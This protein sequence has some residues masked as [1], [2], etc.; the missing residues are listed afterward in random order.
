MTE[1]LGELPVL[2]VRSKLPSAA[3]AVV[4]ARV[5]IAAVEAKAVIFMGVPFVGSGS[6]KFR[7]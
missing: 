5:S 1:T 2:R 4:A 6:L 3:K 7:C